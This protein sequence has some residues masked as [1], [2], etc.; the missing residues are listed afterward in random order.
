VFFI[1]GFDF[2]DEMKQLYLVRHAKSSWA[3]G[4]QADFDRPLN[5]RGKKDAPEMGEHLRT[6]R[7]VI[8]DLVLCSPA[9]R[10]KATA[11]R[12]LKGLQYPLGQVVWEARI[13]SGHTADLL[14]LICSVEDHF[15][16]VMVI[17]HNPYMT[18]LVNFLSKEEIGDM[19][20]CGVFGLAFEV[21]TWSAIKN[22]RGLKLFYDVPKQ[23]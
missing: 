13:Y 22:E 4:Q 19:P 18:D 8:L 11:K 17:G 3:E 23:I 14:A 10:A 20:T 15:K 21:D 2:G 7:A 6:R 16:S 5:S 1:W 12:L 9:K